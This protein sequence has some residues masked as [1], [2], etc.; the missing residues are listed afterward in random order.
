MAAQVDDDDHSDL[1]KISPPPSSASLMSYNTSSIKS[2]PVTNDMF[3]GVSS[4]SPFSSLSSSQRSEAGVKTQ[5]TMTES[6][7]STDTAMLSS[8]ETEDTKRGIKGDGEALRDVQSVVE[9][10]VKRVRE[11]SDQFQHAAQP[12]ADKTRSFAERRPVLFTFLALWAAFSA[13]PILI[14]LGFALTATTVIAFS[15]AFFIAMIIIGTILLTAT[16]II[17]TVLGAFVLLLPFLFFTTVLAVG[18]LAALLG[19]FLIHRLYLHLSASSVDQG[20]NTRSISIGVRSWADET[21]ERVPLPRV[22]AL[23]RFRSAGGPTRKD[24]K[25]GVDDGQRGLNDAGW[26]TEK[27]SF[28][29]YIP[30]DDINSRSKT[31]GYG[32]NWMEKN[33]TRSETS[34]ASSMKLWPMPM[35]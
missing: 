19:L 6:Q 17:G 20:L 30:G 9:D 8:S 27:A 32:D 15:S 14:F 34:P 7:V 18:A 33:T 13:I 24:E 2:E 12:Y 10:T 5:G 21:I 31:M 25:V 35:K 29:H 16:V 28:G 26:V 3:S 23:Q 22:S 4:R 11:R 1:V